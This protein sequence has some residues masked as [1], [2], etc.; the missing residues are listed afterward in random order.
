MLRT[1]IQSLVCISTQ[2]LLGPSVMCAALNYI[3]QTR[4][5]PLLHHHIVPPL[6]HF[7][8]SSITTVSLVE[9]IQVIE[10][11]PDLHLS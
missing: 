8:V 10:V 4:D 2:S 9:G 11:Y 3:P 5:I 7:G 1:S 6:H